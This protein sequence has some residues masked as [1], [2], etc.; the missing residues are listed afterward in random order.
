MNSILPSSKK[1]FKNIVLMNKILIGDASASHFR[2]MSGLLTKARHDPLNVENI[3]TGKV[4]GA[5]HESLSTG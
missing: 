5:K 1:L 4:E 2:V 3:E